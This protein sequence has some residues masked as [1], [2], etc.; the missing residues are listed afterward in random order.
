[1][2]NK[3]CDYRSPYFKN[4]INKKKNDGILTHTKLPEILLVILSNNSKVN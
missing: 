1:M 2:V 4:F 3:V